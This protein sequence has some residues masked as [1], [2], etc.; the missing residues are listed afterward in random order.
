MIDELVR[1][2]KDFATFVSII[3]K[4]M[5]ANGLFGESKFDEVLDDEDLQEYVRKKKIDKL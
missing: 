4:S 2:N 5:S 1:I 3:N